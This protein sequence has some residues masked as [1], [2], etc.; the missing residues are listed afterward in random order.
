MLKYFLKTIFRHS[1]RYKLFTFLNIVGLAI[2]LTVCLL[3]SLYVQD[4]L[5]YDRFHADADNIYRVDMSF[6]WGDTD[7]RFGSTP[8]PVASLLTE[9][10]PEI[11]SA[12]RLTNFGLLFVSVGEG[13]EAKAFDEENILMVDSTFFDI[14]TVHILEQ[15]FPDAAALLRVWGYALEGSGDLANAARCFAGKAPK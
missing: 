8:P 3:V 6:I 5:S 12:V 10:F 7:E 11:T 14:F 1:L 9:N 4:D 13:G 15:S 2:G